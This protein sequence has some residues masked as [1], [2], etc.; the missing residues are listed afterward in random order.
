MAHYITHSSLK[1]FVYGGFIRDFIFHGIPAHDLDV[2]VS[3]K[4]SL[5][6]ALDA[7]VEWGKSQ[8]EIVEL[9]WVVQSLVRDLC[10]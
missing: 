8:V 10:L 6:S 3:D 1:S 4:A 2:T 9:I 5:R 7:L